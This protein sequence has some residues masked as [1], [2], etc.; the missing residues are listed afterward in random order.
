MIK[1]L[2]NIKRN[3][4]NIPGWR[5]NR[6][7]LVIESDDWG[8]VRIKDKRTYSLLKE[9]GLN[10]DAIHYDSYES[11]E[12]DQDLEMLF[13]LLLSLKDFKGN[14]LVFTAM[15]NMGNP[16]CDRI[17]DSDYKQYFFQPLE[18]T[19]KEYEYSSNI[20]KLWN[21]GYDL[22][23]FVPEIHGREHINIRRYMK[24]LKSH[25]LKKG[26]RYALDHHSVGPSAFKGTF[27]PNYLGALHPEEKSE[28]EEL[29]DQILNAGVLFKRYLGYHPRVFIAPNAEEPKELESSLKK[30]GVS[31][32]TR[33]KKRTYP[34]GDGVFANE[35]NF[36]GRRNELNQIILNRN[37]FFEPVSFG[38]KE[39][40]K[41]WI[42]SCLNEIELAF[43]WRK[44]A[45]ISSHRVNYVGSINPSNREKGLFALRNLI[46][47][48]LK[49]WPDL[50][51]MSSY[52][53]GEMIRESKHKE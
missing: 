27:Y 26:L 11:L 36:I 13:N 20:L 21:K 38:S 2:Q 40:E 23:I 37:A 4:S 32:L 1:S 29:H 12:S 6:R 39:L 53:L 7:I 10:V 42:L 48:A 30:I 18:E 34:L 19:I 51:F 5:T 33:S 15:C 28:I 43:R 50:E 8:S 41:D 31:Y 17:K 14:S 22:N 45:V 9:A 47:R 44:P 3:I 46:E 16:D 49:K 25:P 24:I 52:Q 35:W